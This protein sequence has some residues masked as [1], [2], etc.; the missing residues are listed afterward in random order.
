MGGP[1]RRGRGSLICCAG[2]AGRQALASQA[3]LIEVSGGGGRKCDKWAFR[4][5]A[6]RKAAASAESET[7][8]SHS[9]ASAA[10]PLIFSARESLRRP[11][12]RAAAGAAATRSSAER[13]AIPATS[14]RTKFARRPPAPN[15][16]PLLRLRPA[17]CCCQRRRLLRAL[18]AIPVGQVGGGGDAAITK[19]GACSAMTRSLAACDCS[20]NKP[21]PTELN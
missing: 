16:N 11:S 1:T 3:A 13:P 20:A 6:T 5:G 12:E 8:A 7:D 9:L 15:L 21:P 17:T 10:E 2:A 4:G 18:G 14:W 19:P